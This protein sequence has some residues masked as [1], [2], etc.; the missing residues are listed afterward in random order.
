MSQDG[1]SS[2]ANTEHSCRLLNPLHANESEEREIM[3][4]KRILMLTCAAFVALSLPIGGVAYAADGASSALAL[5]A[6]EQ[7]PEVLI[8]RG[9]NPK[10]DYIA[11]TAPDPARGMTAHEVLA[12]LEM[13]DARIS[14]DPDG[15]VRIEDDNIVGTGSLLF[16]SEGDMPI[17]LVIMGDASGT[18]QV[19]LSQLVGL[20]AAFRGLADLQHPYLTAVDFNG[21]GKITLTDIVRESSLY[22]GS[23]GSGEEPASGPSSLFA[24]MPHYYGLRGYQYGKYQLN[25]IIADDGSFTGY[26]VSP[27][28][29]DWQDGVVVGIV[30]DF[31]KVHGHFADPVA[32][33]DRSY[34]L[35]IA[36]FEFEQGGDIRDGDRL[37]RRIRTES[38][39]AENHPDLPDLVPMRGSMTL[40]VEGTTISEIEQAMGSDWSDGFG[41]LSDAIQRS[42]YPENGRGGILM[43]NGYMLT[44]DDEP[45]DLA[46]SLG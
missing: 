34:T 9:S 20:A 38:E 40:F 41:S 13:P 35:P 29:K 36:D 18:G 22:L 16:D 44:R 10:L 17:T 3:V 4:S 21:D 15:S 42:L 30:N 12:Y 32:R 8:S 33:D 43:R 37:Y 31:A 19:T 5:S 46:D 23:A 39:L 24:E 1:V 26:L 25:L 7:A 28:A 11:L 45:T 2:A 6:S 14:S 27:T